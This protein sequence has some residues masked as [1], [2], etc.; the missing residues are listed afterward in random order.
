MIAADRFDR[1]G[2][3]LLVVNADG[4]LQ[5][6]KRSE[7]GDLFAPGDLVVANDAATLPASFTLSPRLSRKNRSLRRRITTTALA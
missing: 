5:R 7:L 6:L 4:R 1:R 3:K 2:G